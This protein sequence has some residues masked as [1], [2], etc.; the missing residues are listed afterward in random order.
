MAYRRLPEAL[1]RCAGTI[2]V[3]HALRPFGVVRAGSGEIDPHED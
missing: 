3:L 2:W 1:A